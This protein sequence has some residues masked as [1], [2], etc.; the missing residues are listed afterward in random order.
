M[1]LSAVLLASG[2]LVGGAAH[3]SAGTIIAPVAGVI[4]LGGPGFGSL[5]ETFN[6][7]GL[8]ATYVG[9]VTDFDTYIATNP[10]HSFLFNGFEWFS[11]AGSSS[12]QVTYDFGSIFSIDALALWNEEQAGI[13]VLSVYGSTDAVTFAPL[14]TTSEHE[15]PE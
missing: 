6:Q 11:N 3:A 15:G 5:S 10:L 13:G 4:N 12:A 2:L 14:L 9:G 8:F 7:A 1:K